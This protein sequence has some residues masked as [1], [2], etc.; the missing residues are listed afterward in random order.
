MRVISGFLKGRKFKR[1]NDRGIRP[2]TDREK[3][4]IFNWLQH[5]VDESLV[6]DLFSGTG[7]LGIEA[8][9]RGCRK[10]VFV[11]K[12]SSSL[13]ILKD[14]LRE[15]EILDKC[16]IFPKDVLKFLQQYKSEP[17]DI[18]FI[19][20]PFTQKM[21]LDVLEILARS[22]V[23]KKDTQVI[24][25]ATT[26]EWSEERCPELFEVVKHKSL[27]DKHVFWFRCKD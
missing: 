17:F 2:T 22:K 18:V 21:G 19:D 4:T 12:S 3:E 24:L 15:F 1:F 16:E 6:L 13:R 8:I 14:N 9:S 5:Y 23:L 20:P 25:E 11:D 7:S 27:G 10:A 26:H